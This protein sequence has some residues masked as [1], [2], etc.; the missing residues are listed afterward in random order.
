[1]VDRTISISS[2]RH[3][4]VIVLVFKQH[5]DKFFTGVVGRK[6]GRGGG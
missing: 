2:F 6:G 3:A 1:M 5:K 4:L